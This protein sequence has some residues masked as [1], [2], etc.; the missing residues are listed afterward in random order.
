MIYA[1]TVLG[2]WVVLSLLGTWFA[3]VLIINGLK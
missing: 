3:V 1:L 2:F